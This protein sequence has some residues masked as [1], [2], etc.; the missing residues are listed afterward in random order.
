MG[1][2][3]IVLET[4]FFLAREHHA[5]ALK[6]LIETGFV[7]A[8]GDAASADASTLLTQ[9][10][11]EK[12]WE[13]SP[14]N[15]GNFF[16]LHYRLCGR[17]YTYILEEIAPWVRPGSY[18]FV[19]KEQDRPNLIKMVFEDGKLSWEP[20]V[21]FNSRLFRRPID[22]LERALLHYGI[23]DAHEQDKAILEHFLHAPYPELQE[24]A[25]HALLILANRRWIKHAP[26]SFPIPSGLK[27]D[28]VKR[29]KDQWQSGDRRDRNAAMDSLIFWF[30]EDRELAEVLEQVVARKDDLGLFEVELSILE[31]RLKVLRLLN[32]KSGGV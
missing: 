23:Y 5:A 3:E 32:E 27:R 13:V 17:C 15:A 18:V 29:M 26:H 11:A 22:A 10:L 16:Q 30:S 4:E 31:H 21:S 25:A 24:R 12:H 20:A 9:L 14:D 28:W 8:D 7:I 1:Q 19:S 6:H 2:W